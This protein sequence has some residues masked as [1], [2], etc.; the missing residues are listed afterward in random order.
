M[1]K[2]VESATDELTHLRLGLDWTGSLGRVFER[3]TDRARSVL[4]LAQ[5]EARLLNHSFIGTEHLLLG[6]ISE[7]EGVA[8]KALGSLGIELGAVR[9]RVRATMTMP[10][11]V[12][13]SGSPPF[14]PRAKKVLELA[15]R[16]ALQL[17]HSYIG[18]EHL[19]LGLVREGQ[20][21]GVQALQTLGAEPS[22]VRQRVL[23]FLTGRL[24]KEFD[25]RTEVHRRGLHQ[26]G[27]IEPKCP[28]CKA[29][30]KESARYRSMT[31]PPSTPESPSLTVETVSC[32]LCGILLGMFK[33][34]SSE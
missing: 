34:E 5:E 15:L 23:Q 26:S 13:E 21:V 30:L 33:T 4:V 14:T 31:I 9:E 16:E 18:T 29:D 32:G 17:G 28:G 20:G 22:Q 1:P 11:D 25:E 12:T 6:L 24:E 19:L 3:F 27:P 10:V 7:G 2:G 8:A